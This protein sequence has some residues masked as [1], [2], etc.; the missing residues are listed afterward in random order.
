[1]ELKPG[2]AF[3]A[4][5]RALLDRPNGPRAGWLLASLSFAFV[6]GRLREA[7]GGAK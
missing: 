3:A 7:A 4:L 6:A 5:Y 1:M 2:D